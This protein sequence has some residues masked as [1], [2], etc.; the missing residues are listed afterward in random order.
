MRRAVSFS[1][2]VVLVWTVAPHAI[3]ADARPTA[4]SKPSAPAETRRKSYNSD[5]FPSKWD[6]SGIPYG[7]YHVKHDG[8]LHV[9]YDPKTPDVLEFWFVR[10]EVPIISLGGHRWSSFT[11][12]ENILLF[13]DYRPMAPGCA[14]EGYDLNDGKRLWRTELSVA[15]PGSPKPDVRTDYFTRAALRFNKGTLELVVRETAGHYM[16][17][18]DPKTGKRQERHVYEQNS[19]I[20]GIPG[21][22]Y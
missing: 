5:S 17:I 10:D 1:I 4:K 9:V 19:G 11:S 20:P 8:E 14:V 15:G 22:H 3:A 7:W 12:W 2:A 16:E 13:A 21:T 6:T 18:L